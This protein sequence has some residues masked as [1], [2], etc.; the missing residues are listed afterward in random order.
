M[1]DP[2]FRIQWIDGGREPQCASDPAYPN[3]VDVNLV[4]AG[5]DSCKAALPYPAKRCG[6]HLVRCTICGFTIGGTAAGR[7]DDPRSVRVPCSQ[8]KAQA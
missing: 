1:S 5:Q 2:Q 6:I 4:P 7:P 3:G 8:R